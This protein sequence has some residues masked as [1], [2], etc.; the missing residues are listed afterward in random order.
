MKMNRKRKIMSIAIV[1]LFSL[2]AFTSITSAMN[3]KTLGEDDDYLFVI[4]YTINGKAKQVPFMLDHA[5]V[6]IRDYQTNDEICRKTSGRAGSGPGATPF[7]ELYYFDLDGKVADGTKLNITAY[8]RGLEAS[9]TITIDLGRL[10]Y[11]YHNFEKEFGQEKAFTPTILSLIQSR[12]DQFKATSILSR[13]L[14]K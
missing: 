12:T 6:V 9:R 11:A 8:W 3:V 4:C 1:A 5:T 14:F 13:L 2:M 10:K 7:D